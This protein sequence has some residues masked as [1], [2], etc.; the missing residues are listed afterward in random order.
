MN[1][2][3]E[4][5]NQISQEE[6]EVFEPRRRVETRIPETIKEFRSMMQMIT[7][8]PIKLICILTAKW[9]ESWYRDL[10]GE[11]KYERDRSKHAMIVNYW[12][13]ATRAK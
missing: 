12:L 11:L 2:L 7:K 1:S 4:I 3:D 10:Y 13:K 6:P 5:Y 8:R 9:P